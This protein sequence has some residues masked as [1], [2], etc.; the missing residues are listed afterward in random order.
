MNLLGAHLGLSFSGGLLD[1]LFFNLLTT[2]TNWWILIPVG[3]AFFAINYFMFRFAIVKFN[4]K[5]PGRSKDLIETKSTVEYDGDQISNIIKA[6]G[7][8]NNIKNVNACYSR[9]R[10]DVIDTSIV[11]KDIFAEQ[12]EASGISVL[13]NNVQVIYGN[14]AV[15][16]KEGVLAV[17]SGKEAEVLSSK[18][19]ANISK[20]PKK[21][22]EIAAPATGEILELERVED[23]VFSEKVMGDGFAIELTENTIYA[24]VSGKVISVFPT[25]HAI[26]MVDDFGNEVLIHIGLDTVKLDGDGFRLHMAVGDYVEQGD[27]I[28]E[29]DI[30]LIKSKGYSVVTPIIFTNLDQAKYSVKIVS[31]KMV[32]SNQK[33]IIDL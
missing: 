17:L 20:D 18:V 11:D 30:D 10:V 25:K 16:I 32:K 31:E 22:I 15:P 6:L 8:K 33:K 7:G 14:Q 21:L 24:P 12:L 9:L 28:A 1:F 23:K 29:I 2:R 3:L 4:L 19:E 5:T 13:G 27:L 26:G